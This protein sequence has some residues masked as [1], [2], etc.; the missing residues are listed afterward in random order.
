[1]IWNVHQNRP[2]DET[3]HLD[4]RV[5]GGVG[6]GGVGM[7]GEPPE[8]DWSQLLKRIFA[9]ALITRERNPLLTWTTFE[10]KP[11]VAS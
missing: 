10:M 1:M 8:C 2:P 6:W 11:S 5:W 9:A 4:G 3:K 7:G